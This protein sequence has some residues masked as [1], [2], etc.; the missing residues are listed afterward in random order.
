MSL[1]INNNEFKSI[2]GYEGLYEINQ[3][4]DIKSIKKNI[5][6]KNQRDRGYCKIELSKNG[7]GKI[8]KI[9]RLVWQTFNDT[10]PNKMEINHINGIKDDNRIEN[11]ELVT[12]SQ[13]IIHLYKVLGHKAVKG[14]NH[15]NS[16]KIL[17]TETGIYYD[18]FKEASEAFCIKYT[19]LCAQLNGQNKN[20]TSFKLV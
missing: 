2:P 18:S 5:I 15:K 9:H 12:R 19:T 14:S 4:G 13:N 7:I 6:L 8:F 20:N 17:N 1:L 3:K 16:K 11:L 10:I